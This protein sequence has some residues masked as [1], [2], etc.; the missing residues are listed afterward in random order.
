MD[1]LLLSDD[2]HGHYA[3]ELLQKVDTLA[4]A[5]RDGENWADSTSADRLLAADDV[6]LS[7]DNDGHSV[8]VSSH[9]VSDLLQ[10]LLVDL[11]WGDIDLSQNNEHWQAKSTGD[12]QVLLGHLGYASVRGNHKQT[13]VRVQRGQTVHRCLEVL[14]VTAHVE[15]VH[16]LGRRTDKVRPYLVL[17]RGMRQLGHVLVA[18]GIEAYDLV[19][20]GGCS[21]VSLLMLEVEHLGSQ[22][23]IAIIQGAR[24]RGQKSRK[25]GLAS[26]DITKHGHSQIVCRGLHDN[27]L[28]LWL[29]GGL[30]RYLR[31]LLLLF[32]CYISLLF[33]FLGQGLVLRLWL[34]RALCGLHFKIINNYT[35]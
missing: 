14:L 9:D 7:L 15:Q 10:V 13:V 2:G 24:W 23:S 35:I 18:L 29:V 5:S 12:T 3:Q 25:R 28:L 19:G 27:R 21:A 1:T 17:L 6:R 33:K 31:V 4:S 30:S 26:I 32:C 8:A 34:R 20:D 22:E 16:D 11:S